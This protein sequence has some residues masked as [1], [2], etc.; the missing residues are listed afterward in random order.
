LR[1]F[2]EQPALSC[3]HSCV[4]LGCHPATGN[5]PSAASRVNVEVIALPTFLQGGAQRRSELLG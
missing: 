5:T 3:V 2:R 4:Q 1:H